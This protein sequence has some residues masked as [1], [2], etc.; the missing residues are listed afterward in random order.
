MKAF[1]TLLNPDVRCEIGNY[2][3]LENLYRVVCSQRNL[4]YYFAFFIAEIN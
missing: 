3:K 2:I 4:I 1:H